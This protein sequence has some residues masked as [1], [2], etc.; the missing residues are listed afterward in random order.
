LATYWNRA[1]IALFWTKSVHSAPANFP[2]RIRPRLG[3]FRCTA[4]RIRV[5][6]LIGRSEWISAGHSFLPIRRYLEQE[7]AD[8]TVVIPCGGTSEMLHAYYLVEE[9]SAF[10][11]A[12]H[13]QRPTSASS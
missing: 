11:D 12:Y 4:G 7:Q 10:R 9:F 6:N 5:V 2:L 8:F 13:V 1:E 3:I